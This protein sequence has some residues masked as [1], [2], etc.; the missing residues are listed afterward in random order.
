MVLLLGLVPEG[1]FGLS[2]LDFS[3]VHRGRGEHVTANP[4]KF[5]IIGVT[6]P[7][8]AGY[9]ETLLH[10]PEAEIVAGYDWVDLDLVRE[11]L[12]EQLRGMPLYDDV[13]TLLDRERPEA[14]VICMPPLQTPAL[15]ELA[16]SRGI[17][18]IAEKPCA[19]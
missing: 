9:A 4:V 19:R 2:A 3:P 11:K 14:V 6:Q 5:A 17:H 18:I 16:A 1:Y 8:A 13:T 7:H 12:P 10:M 15:V